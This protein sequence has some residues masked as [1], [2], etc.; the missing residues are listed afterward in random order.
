MNLTQRISAFAELGSQINRLNT[1][2]KA[3]LADQAAQLNAWF[4]PE[5]VNLA[6]AGVSKFLT[7]DT[8]NQWT[9]SYS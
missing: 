3:I 4:T 8:L 5:S 6:L 9:A 7:V 1:D 2:E